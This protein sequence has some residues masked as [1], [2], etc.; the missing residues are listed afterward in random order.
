MAD[1][2]V[3]IDGMY[4]DMP[5]LV[6]TTPDVQMETTVETQPMVP[7]QTLPIV[8]AQQEVVTEN[9]QNNDEEAIGEIDPAAVPP[10]QPSKRKRRTG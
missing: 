6:M 2:S 10:P 8:A 3:E 5:P 4:C 7:L 1:L 9:N